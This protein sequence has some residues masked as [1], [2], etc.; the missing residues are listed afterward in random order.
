[1]I[2]KD[3]SNK[4]VWKDIEGYEGLYQISNL[5]RVKSLPKI[6]GRTLVEERILSPVLGNRGYKMIMLYKNNGNKR[7][8]IHRLIAKAFIPNISNK[9]YINHKDGNKLN[10]SIENLEWCTCRENI[11]HALNMGLMNYVIAPKGA[12]AKNAALKQ[13]DV[14][15]IRNTFIPRDKNFGVNA[16]AKKF[17][18]HRRTISN[19]I[20]KNTYKDEGK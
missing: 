17:N 2:V 5:G 7:F 18:V 12:K 13:E 11:I 1:M 8:S 10:N 9:P 3:L 14:N 6:R 19:V 4:E 16:L 20:H 15:Y